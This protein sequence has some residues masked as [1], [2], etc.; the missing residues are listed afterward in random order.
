MSYW[1]HEEAETALGHAAV[2]CA[3]HATPK[4]AIAFHFEFER[5]IDLLQLNQKLGT[6]KDDGIRSCPLQRFPYSLV[7]RKN[8]DAGPRV[9]AVAQQSREPG[10]WRG[11]SQA[12]RR[13]CPR[14]R[15]GRWLVILARADCRVQLV[16]SLNDALNLTT[17]GMP[18]LS[19]T[20]CGSIHSS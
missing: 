7:Y 4:I 14:W 13:R 3:E 15:R 16:R 5:V 20:R 9:Y 19:E 18:T 17:G 2:Y 6:R 10:N 8:Q 1:L 11:R 12:S